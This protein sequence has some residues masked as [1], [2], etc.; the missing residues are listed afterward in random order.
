MAAI[1]AYDHQALCVQLA[2]PCNFQ[3]I[4]VACIANSQTN[5]TGLY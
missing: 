1:I 3:S 5:S 4:A 2:L